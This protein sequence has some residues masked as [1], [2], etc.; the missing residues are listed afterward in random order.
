MCWYVL[1]HSKKLHWTIATFAHLTC[2]AHR[3]SGKFLIF[4]CMH[5]IFHF[6]DCTRIIQRSSSSSRCTILCCLVFYIYVLCAFGMGILLLSSLVLFSLFFRFWK[7]F[8]CS[9]S[10][11]RFAS[12]LQPFLSICNKNVSSSI[13]SSRS[14]FFGCVLCFVHSAAVLF[15]WL[16]VFLFVWCCQ[17]PTW[18]GVPFTLFNLTSSPFRSFHAT[19]QRDSFQY[20]FGPFELG[21]TYYVYMNTKRKIA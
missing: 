16:Y 13:F 15:S 3:Q 20:S 4:T 18:S 10:I 8:L 9:R 11:A 21:S 19:T 14:V 7:T 17:I 1:F 2:W 5:G 6:D 12:Q